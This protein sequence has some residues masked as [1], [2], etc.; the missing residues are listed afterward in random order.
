MQREGWGLYEA[1]SYVSRNHSENGIF[2]E[3]VLPIKVVRRAVIMKLQEHGSLKRVTFDVR[4]DR[5]C[6]I[7]DSLLCMNTAIA[8][9]YI[10]RASNGVSPRR[11]ATCSLPHLRHNSRVLGT[12]MTRGDENATKTAQTQPNADISLAEDV[13]AKAFNHLI[14]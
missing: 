3:H 11:I 7:S 13:P 14:L 6:H 1:L 2:T 10:C 12:R 4:L 8:P 5:L 9:D